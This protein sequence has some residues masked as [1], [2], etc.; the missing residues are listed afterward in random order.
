MTRTMKYLR[1]ITFCAIFVFPVYTHAAPV[2][3]KNPVFPVKAFVEADARVIQN[4]ST[5]GLY[6]L[7][8]ALTATGE[9]VFL[10][11]QPTRTAPGATLGRA[12]VHYSIHES[13]DGVHRGGIAGAFLWSNKKAENGFY[14]LPKGS[15]REFTLVV[16]Y[17]NTGGEKDHYQVR[18]DSLEYSLGEVDNA[19]IPEVNG[20]EQY[21]TKEIELG[22]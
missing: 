19:V 5:T 21:K 15:T 18:L 16:A 7:T 13:D 17:K 4:A 3:Q 14:V 22:S 6:L 2:A 9:D 12:G 1:V 8:F 10:P 20:F 11:V